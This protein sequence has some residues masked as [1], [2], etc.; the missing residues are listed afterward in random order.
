MSAGIAVGALGCGQQLP[1]GAWFFPAFPFNLTSQQVER[2]GLWDVQNRRGLGLC[3][4]GTIGTDRTVRLIIEYGRT[5]PRCEAGAIIFTTARW[6]L[7]DGCG[8]LVN[9]SRNFQD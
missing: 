1:S 2:I 4:L 8:C 7:W 3:N 6:R 9:G 5:P